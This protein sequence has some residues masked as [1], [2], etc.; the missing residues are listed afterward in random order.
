M[1]FRDIAIWNVVCFTLTDALTFFALGFLAHF[2]FR[3]LDRGLS[4]SQRLTHFRRL[5]REID[6]W[7]DETLNKIGAAAGVGV[8]NVVSDPLAREGR[9]G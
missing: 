4:A 1:E 7:T 9:S 8:P 3:V 2:F 5:T 6:V